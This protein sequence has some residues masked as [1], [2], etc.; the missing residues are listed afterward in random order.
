[1]QLNRI[2]VR[3]SQLISEQWKF[4]I[5]TEAPAE[6][7]LTTFLLKNSL[8]LIEYEPVG[9]VDDKQRLDGGLALAVNN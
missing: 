4:G 5:S 9:K 1:M 3:M 2:I 6:E 7:Y 8:S